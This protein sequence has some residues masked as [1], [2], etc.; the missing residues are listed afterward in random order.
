MP[1]RTDVAPLAQAPAARS[2]FTTFQWPLSAAANSGVRPFCAQ[3]DADSRIKQNT[4][5]MATLAL[6]GVFAARRSSRAS[7]H[8]NCQPSLPASCFGCFTKN[9]GVHPLWTPLWTPCAPPAQPCNSSLGFGRVPAPCPLTH[10]QHSVLVRAL[11]EQ[12][13][14]D[15]RMALPRRHEQRGPARLPVPNRLQGMRAAVYSSACHTRRR[16]SGAPLHVSFPLQRARSGE[17]PSI[18]A[19]RRRLPCQRPRL[20]AP[21]RRHPRQPSQ[22]CIA[23]YGRPARQHRARRGQ[24]VS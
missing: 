1:V 10:R 16:A 11:A 17:A 9:A 12:L 6:R 15:A 19:P 13:L 18:P 22:P 2:S 3:V 7:G 5:G 14:H 20:A 4:L 21:P 24:R 8:T 23:P